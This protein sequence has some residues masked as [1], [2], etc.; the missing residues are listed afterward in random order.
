MW[1]E[2]LFCHQRPWDCGNSFASNG[3]CGLKQQL[4]QVFCVRH[5]NSFAS[6][7][8]CGLKHRGSWCRRCLVP[9]FIRQQWRMWIETEIIPALIRSPIKFIRQQWRM[10]IETPL[11]ITVPH[12]KKNSFASNGECGL[13]PET[14]S[15][16]ILMNEFIRQ[17][18]RMWIET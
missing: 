17:Q 7:G 12:W 4:A 9:Q 16:H 8:E 3:E 14:F 11:A 10:W 6:N 18:W 15:I 5:R 1:I 13:K 2:T